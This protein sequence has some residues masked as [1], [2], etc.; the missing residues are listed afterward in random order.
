MDLEGYN[1]E[2]LEQIIIN[3]TKVVKN[4]MDTATSKVSYILTYQL[5]TTPVIRDLESQ[6]K[7]LKDFAIHLG[8]TMHSYRGYQRIKAELRERCK[9]SY[10]KKWEDRINNISENNITTVNNFGIKLN[11]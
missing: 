8:W 2:Q 4:A 5:K 1:V 10:N 9:D 3:W 11:D 7:T 6:I